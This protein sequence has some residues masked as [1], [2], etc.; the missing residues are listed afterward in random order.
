LRVLR[1]GQGFCGELDDMI[2]EI[3]K[4]IQKD[5]PSGIELELQAS[6]KP[7]FGDYFT[8]VAFQLVPMMKKS[9]FEI[10]KELAQK[11]SGHP[12]FSK[13]EAIAPGFINF[14]LAPEFLQNEVKTILKTKKKYGVN[15]VSPALKINLEFVSANPTGPLT[16]ANGRGGF[17]GDVLGNVLEKVGHKVTKEY[18]VNDAGNQVRL[19][20]ESILAVAGHPSAGGPAAGNHYKGVYIKTLEKKLK[21]KNGVDPETLGKKAAV[22]LLKEIRASLKKAGINHKVWFSEDKNLHKKKELDKVLAALRVKN[23][24]EK[25]D[26]AEWLGDNVLIKSDGNSTYFLADLAYHYDKFIK[27]KFDVAIDIWGADHHG[28][29]A[30]MKNGV[31]ALG[32]DSKKLQILITQ[33]VRLIKDG[34]EVKMSKRTG[35]F[36][37]L[38]ELIREVGK[39]AA[40]FFFLMHSLD[41]HMDFDMGLAKEKSQKNPVFYVQYAYVRVI[42]I[43]A[44]SGKRKTKK[45][46]FDLLKSESEQKLIREMV[47]LPDVIAQTAKDYQVNRLTTYTTELARAFH[48]FYEKERVVGVGE[49]LEAAR[50]GLMNALKIVLENVFDLMEISTPKKM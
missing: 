10:A 30:R 42:N 18:Y 33:L 44:K 20:G 25:K 24:T 14:H 26:G 46:N 16:M 41:T 43:L 50:V 35:E 22:I 29:I 36:I 8:N 6:D 2:Q 15:K 4:I 47:R 34:Q 27:R 39:D 9:P 28:Y 7:E 3:K 17:Y 12:E 45:I 1:L 23:R 19:L 32:I 5:I 38:D 13:V 37:T 49:E 40:R 11:F 48:N 31:E 21:P